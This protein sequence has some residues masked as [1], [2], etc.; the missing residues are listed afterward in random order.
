MR[1]LLIALVA[2]GDVGGVVAWSAV[3]PRLHAPPTRACSRGTFMQADEPPL[4]T[5]LPPPP[6]PP[7]PPPTP[8]PDLFI[9]AFVTIAL[10]GYGLILT[11]DAIQNGV[12]LFGQCYGV[13]SQPSV[14]GS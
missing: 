10:G 1:A 4:P 14:W 8:A 2:L 11:F 6:P 5:S 3:S 9:P 7:P 13:A 12:C